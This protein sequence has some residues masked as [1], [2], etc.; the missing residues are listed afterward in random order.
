M[1]G[2]L[3]RVVEHDDR[4]RNFTVTAVPVVAS[5]LH[6]RH[7]PVFDQG[8]LGSCTGNAAAGCMATGPW[9]HR[10]TER[11]AVLLYERATVLDSFPG[12]YPPD[13]TGSSGLAVMKA[14]QARHWIT[15]YHH[16]FSFNDVLAALQTT[17]V[18]AGVNWYEGFD[19]PDPAGNVRIAGQVRGGHEVCVVGCD[20][21]AQ[22][23]RAV[24]S[25]SAGWGD[26]GYFT[27]TYA[28]FERLLSEQGDVTVPV[29]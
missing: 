16:A 8:D 26:H 14:V 2:A 27:W 6:S 9:H 25:W 11:T 7:V 17:P 13:D 5:V 15:A 23:I 10:C 19:Q 12:S 3:G 24:N 21:D 1:A 4:S 20:V 22:T 18:I 29:L 28:D